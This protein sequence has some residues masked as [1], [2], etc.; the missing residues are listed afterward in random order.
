MSKAIHYTEDLKE[1]PYCGGEEFYILQSY[2][3]TCYYRVRFDGEEADNG[4]MYDSATHNSLRKYAYCCDCD[5][6][7]FP[8]EEYYTSLFD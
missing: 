8:I 1:C 4:D 2:S 3:G 5:K 7:L 6:R